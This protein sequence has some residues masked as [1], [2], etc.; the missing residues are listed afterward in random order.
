M[1]NTVLIHYISDKEKAEKVRLLLIKTFGVAD[2]VEF[3]AVQVG[4]S[5]AYRIE[6]NHCFGITKSKD[7]MYYYAIG[8]IDTLREEV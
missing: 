4:T 8:C 1:E 5:N 6:I 7:F 2:A 3:Q